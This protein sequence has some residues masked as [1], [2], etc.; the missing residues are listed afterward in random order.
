M[1]KTITLL[2]VALL[3]FG[4]SA[5]SVKPFTGKRI[6][7][8]ASSQFSSVT[9][10]LQFIQAKAPAKAA[11]ATEGTEASIFYSP[12][13]YPYT[14]VYLKNQEAGM[15]V[16]QAMQLTPSESTKFAG[17]KITNILFYSG[18][19]MGVSSQTN[20]INTISKATLFL[21]DNLENFNPFYTQDIELSNV[22]L[23]INNIKLDTPYTIE[24]GK[25]L[26]V[27]YYCTL[28]SKNDAIFVIDYINHGDDVSGG[29]YGIKAAPTEE[30]PDPKWTFGN[31]AGEVGF[32]CIGVTITGDKLPSDEMSVEQ[33]AAG[34]YIT[35]NANFEVQA[36][37]Y[38]N[39]ANLINNIDVEVKVGDL[40]AETIPFE[41]QQPLEYNQGVILSVSDLTYP[42]VSKDGIPVT[43][44]VTKING[45]DNKSANK[46]G[47]C[48]VVVLPT[49]KAY[50][51][52]I[53]VEEFTGTWCQFCPQGYVTMEAMREKYTDGS[54]IPVAVHYDDE[55]Q[56]S[57]YLAVNN[58]YS[59]DSYPSAIMNRSFYIDNIY[60]TATCFEEIEAYKAI[61]AASQVTGTAKVSDD[62]LS[63]EFDVK[64]KFS[65]D[66]DQASKEYGLAFGITED[67]V[68]PY[69][70]TNYY[71]SQPSGTLPGFDNG[72]GAK[73]SLIF[74]DVARQYNNYTRIKG[75]IPDVVE[76]GKEY[77]FHYE[78]QLLAKTKIDD[79]DQ[80]NFIVYLA[81]LKTGEIENACM[82]PSAKRAGVEK[83]IAT[84]TTDAPVEYFNLQGIRV[85]NP[86]HGIFIRRQGNKATKVAF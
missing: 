56:S 47:E 82:I 60:P 11:D 53:V 85:A 33:V 37:V 46:T 57:S 78:M 5:Q 43:V 72:A 74:N 25:D 21:C 22:G 69:P 19:N 68:G 10:P 18:Y 58:A 44:T 31:L 70:Q 67:N 12:A 84:E 63:V 79:Y 73:V 26:Y 34:P 62:E 55:M 8:P 45:N 61:P 29:W 15:S 48:T 20:I 2:T 83:V 40:P 23:T 66:N 52:N 64:T 1:K 59:N 32:F 77:S 81:N 9:I 14:A 7:A 35:Q 36:L 17:N 38:N 86:D 54:V 76:A 30:T 50:Q 41:F 4:A 28:S 13:E 16:A 49:D 6:N 39:A 65:F 42:T 75:S 24:E 51:R 27:G 3:A 71:S 80:V